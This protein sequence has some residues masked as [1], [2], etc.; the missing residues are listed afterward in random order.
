MIIKNSFLF[1]L[2]TVLLAG[3]SIQS[4]KESISEIEN[5]HKEVMVYHDEAMPKL[6]IIKRLGKTLH[7]VS[8]LEEY[9]V[10][11]DDRKQRLNGI[12]V[13]LADAEK[14]MWNWMYAYK[15]PSEL[16]KGVDPIPYYNEELKSVKAMRDK[17]FESI[18]SA[19]KFKKQYGIQ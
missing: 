4:C 13:Q 16:E 2:V 11:P 18:D 10:W 15:I 3:F 6:T 9:K 14:G 7:Q 12:L 17:I 8:E 1:S 5:I 19:E